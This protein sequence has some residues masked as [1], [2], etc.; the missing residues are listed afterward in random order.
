MAVGSTPVY[1]VLGAGGG[2]G[3]ALARLL[4]ADGARL[5]LAGRDS[6][7]LRALGDELDA[8]AL[9]VDARDPAQ[10]ERAVAAA[11]EAHGGLSGVASCVGS[12]LLKPAHL[13]RDE[14]WDEVIATNLTSAFATVRAGARA[15]M[16]EGGGSIVLVAS[17]AAEVGLANHEAIAAAKGGVAA[18]ARAA[19]ATY[20]PR[21]VR[22]NAV[23]PGL[24]ETPLTERITA[25]AGARAA[26]EGMHALG[27][28]GQPGDVARAIA[29]LLHPDNRWVTGQVLGVDGGLAR[30]RAR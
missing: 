13:T 14:E 7:R 19:A 23:A 16:D 2:I 3:S 12:L 26:S 9:A 5:V 18:L 10:V 8:P 22:V 29:W 21:N 17:A 6:D 4:A 25:S 24:T 28:L 15:L 30:V 27:R 20:A 1:L 11:R